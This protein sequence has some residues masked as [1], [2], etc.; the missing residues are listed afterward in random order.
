MKKELDYATIALAQ[1]LINSWKTYHIYEKALVKRLE[2]RGFRKTEYD[3][4]ES[5]VSDSIIGN[6]V[7]DGVAFEESVQEE[8]KTIKKPK[9]KK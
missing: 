8:L 5:F 6:D 9:K 1:M 7:T 3:D 4:A 2:E